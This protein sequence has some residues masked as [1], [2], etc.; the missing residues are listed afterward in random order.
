MHVS[1]AKSTECISSGRAGAWQVAEASRAQVVD[2]HRQPISCLQYSR[3]GSLLV[4]ACV[5]GQ[6]KVW[7]AEGGVLLRTLIR[8]PT[9]VRVRALVFASEPGDR[10]WVGCSDGH[11]RGARLPEQ[12]AEA[13]AARA[14]ADAAAALQLEEQVSREAKRGKRVKKTKEE[15]QMEEDAAALE[16]AVALAAATAAA[17]VGEDVED[18]EKLAHARRSSVPAQGLFGAGVP[19]VAVAHSRQVAASVT[20]DRTS[21]E[22][23]DAQTLAVK[24]HL[25]G[26]IKTVTSLCMDPEGGWLVSGS[27]DGSV[28]VWETSSGRC[29]LSQPCFRQGVAAV[30]IQRE[31]ELAAAGSSLGDVEVI[32]FRAAAIVTQFSASDARIAALHFASDARLLAFAH[33]D[34]V[35]GL[36]DLRQNRTILMRGATSA[37]KSSGI[38]SKQAAATAAAAAELVAD[39]LGDAPPLAVGSQDQQQA[40]GDSL[41]PAPPAPATAPA[42]KGRG[43]MLPGMGRLGSMFSSATKTPQVPVTRALCSSPDGFT[44]VRSLG[45]LVEVWDVRQPSGRLFSDSS[46]TAPVN[47]LLMLDG[48]RAVASAGSDALVK[49]WCVPGRGPSMWGSSVASWSLLKAGSNSGAGQYGDVIHGVALGSSSVSFHCL[50]EVTALGGCETSL[51]AAGDA[52]GRL[53]ALSLLPGR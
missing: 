9:A 12:E 20:K 38:S 15:R 10:V 6:V 1:G 31:V 50:Q 22:L 4:S 19:L 44:L 8:C 34:G 7:D 2:G 53:Y 29:R 45:A 42:N 51:L 48:G 18:Q 24:T 14:K 41:T 27:A 11:V 36:R 23:R 47:A 46:H 26:H 3:S 43:A 13:L 16:E 32:D 49:I 21:I 17:A 25:H 33:H 40:H 37:D 5:G 39:H 28:K 52:A 35:F 30:A